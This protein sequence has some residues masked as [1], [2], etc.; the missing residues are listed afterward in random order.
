[1]LLKAMQMQANA[2]AYGC[3]FY[4]RQMSGLAK[5]RYD[6]EICSGS[7]AAPVPGV[8]VMPQA[9]GQPIMTVK[10][11]SSLDCDNQLE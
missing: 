9:Y 4:Y 10:R 3:Q 6:A 2:Y 7:C 11:G 5:D 1:M 8:G